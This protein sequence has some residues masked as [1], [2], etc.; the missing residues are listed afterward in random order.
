MEEKKERWRVERGRGGSEKIEREG[1]GD[2]VL[3]C[4]VLQVAAAMNLFQLQHQGYRCTT[5]QSWCD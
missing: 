1:V 3:S 5:E 2:D 4:G